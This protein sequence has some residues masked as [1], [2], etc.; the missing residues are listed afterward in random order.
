MYS[1]PIVRLAFLFF[2]VAGYALSS[3]HDSEG[4]Q[5]VQPP[6]GVCSPSDYVILA[7][8]AIAIKCDVQPTEVPNGGQLVL[9]P[10]TGQGSQ[11]TDAIQVVFPPPV[12]P[13]RHQD[14]LIA[15][16]APSAKASLTT[17]ASYVLTLQYA[18]VNGG[19]SP[20]TPPLVIQIDTTPTV[21][22]LSPQKSAPLDFLTKSHIAF[23]GDS[24]ELVYED[25]S[26]SAAE[27][28][29]CLSN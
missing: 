7:P 18:S 9:V 6:A 10:K 1:L 24:K 27:F 19:A 12:P 26:K 21:T 3:V 4:T 8:N 25:T 2:S 29:L 11:I 14:W 13:V 20:V 28:S 5:A 22:L 17:G 23:A 15:Y 16:W